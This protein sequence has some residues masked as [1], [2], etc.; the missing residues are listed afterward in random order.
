[1][2]DPT[3]YNIIH[4]LVVASSIPKFSGDSQCKQLACR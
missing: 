1:V 2:N 3:L 4:T